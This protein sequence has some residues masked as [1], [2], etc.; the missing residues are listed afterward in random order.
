MLRLFRKYNKYLVKI[1]YKSG[2]SETFWAWHFKMVNSTSFEWKEASSKEPFVL[3]ISDIESIWI[4]KE[5][6]GRNKW[7][8]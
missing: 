2:H 1:N 7:Y 3:G 6:P 4:L 5:K 8:V